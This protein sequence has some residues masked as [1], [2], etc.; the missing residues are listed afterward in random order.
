MATNEQGIMALPEGQ[1]AAMPQLS[2]MDSYDAVRQ[3]FKQARPDVDLEVQEV[4][5]QMRTGLDKLDDEQLQALIDAVQYLYDNPDRYKETLTQAIREGDLEQGVFPEEYDEELLSVILAALLDEQRS[6]DTGSGMMMPPPQNFARGGIAEAARLVASQGRNGDT[7]LAHITPAEMRLLKSRGG[8]GTINPVT[9]L[10]EFWNP[11]KAIGKLVTGVGKAVTGVVKGAVNVVKDVVK[12]VVNVAKEI[13]KSPIGRIVATIGLATVLGPGAFGITG[14]GLASAPVA[15][16][17]AS[18]AV[19]ALSGG[20]LKDVLIN[21]VVGFAGAPGGPVSNFVGKYTGQFISNPTVLAAAN[22]AVVGTGAGLLQGQNLKEAVQGGLIQGAVAGTIAYAQGVPPAKANA[23]AATAASRG[24]TAVAAEADDAIARVAK[25]GSPDIDEAQIAR[26]NTAP[27]RPGEIVKQTIMKDGRVYEQSF[28]ATNR[29]TVVGADGNLV[30]LEVPL[31]PAKLVTQGA[32]QPAS[33]AGPTGGSSYTGGSPLAQPSLSGAAPDAMYDLASAAGKVGVRPP[34]GTSFQPGLGTDTLRY[35][36]GMGAVEM[37]NIPAA[38]AGAAGGAAPG[39]TGGVPGV[40]ASLSRAG[41]GVMD[42]AKGNFSQGY[43]QLKGGLGD[44]FFPG[45]PAAPTSADLINNPQ[46][47]MLVDKGVSPD[48]ALQT[49]KTELTPPSPGMLRTYGPGVAA[50][51]T[52]LGLAGGF[53]PKPPPETEFAKDMRQPIDLSD[54]PSA[55]YIQGL[56]GVQY[57]ERGEIIGSS[58]WSPS[59]TMED[60]RVATPSYIGYNPMAYTQPT[61]FNMGGIAALAQGG[62]PRRIGQISG[63][64]TE[65]SDDIPAML[66]DGEFVMTARAVRGAGNGSRR[67]GAKKMYALMH[68]LERNAARG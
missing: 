18:G 38:P 53:T 24:T 14:L 47:K 29:P 41:S 32:V 67:E 2:Y 56:P 62:Y 33:A 26:A 7:M 59:E 23:D 50:G 22:A 12:G 55:Y 40:G 48:I 49:L 19:T 30:D 61:Y 36:A 58:A 68:Q 64:G 27:G 52:A 25:F 21:S 65:T 66:S 1:Q 60:I 51:I 45:T 3:G 37:P 6:R 63:P 31:G 43:E 39:G 34:A 44:L 17:L 15:A 10:P 42:I 35:P 13:V 4:M 11:F 57:N 16:G 20:S 54:N 9:G 46:Y 5:A 28:A 8:S